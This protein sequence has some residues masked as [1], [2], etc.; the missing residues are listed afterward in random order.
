M[1][2]RVWAVAALVAVAGCTPT[3]GRTS[4]SPGESSILT[5]TVSPWPT[6]TPAVT[7]S[8]LPDDQF[9]V[10][11]PV[12][13]PV[14]NDAADVVAKL[15]EVTDGLP[16]LKLDVTVKQITLTVLLPGDGVASYRWEDGRIN[17][18]DSDIQYLGQATFD[19]LSYP[20]RSVGRMFDVADLR[21]VRGEQLL[22]IVEYRPGDLM[23]TVTSR[24]ES[25]TVFFRK[26]GTAVATLGITSVADI[27]DGIAEVVADATAVYALGFNQARGYWAD[28][29]GEADGTV[30]N[31]SRVGGIPVFTTVRNESYPHPSFDPTMI[32]PEALAKAI[33]QFRTAPDQSCSVQIDMSHGRSAPIAKV[34]CG[35]ATHYSDL[36]GRDMTELVEG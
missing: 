36:D 6:P 17:H 19:P 11:F 31:R 23:M 30:A 34:E 21:G 9:P 8:P 32:R 22:Q 2:K 35:G 7:G 14:S 13:G 28:F 1:S 20:L 3:P 5:P 12:F 25:S 33:A 29:P 27:S 15:V 24:P 26:D 10:L 4:P 16:A 18:V